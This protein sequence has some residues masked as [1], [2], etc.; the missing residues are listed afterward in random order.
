[1]KCKPN[2]KAAMLDLYFIGWNATKLNLIEYIPF[3]LG[4]INTFNLAH[5]VGSLSLYE[6]GKSFGTDFESLA[7]T[8]PWMNF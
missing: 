5:Y 1:M 3:K 2:F 4:Y 8:W 6:L 7:E